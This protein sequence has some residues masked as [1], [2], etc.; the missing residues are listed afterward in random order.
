MGDY[1]ISLLRMEVSMETFTIFNRLVT[2]G[3][4]SQDTNPL[5]K[6]INKSSD[7]ELQRNI[8]YASKGLK[9]ILL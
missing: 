1:K 3:K 5:R 2:L 4:I 9:Q 6:I 8:L 7:F